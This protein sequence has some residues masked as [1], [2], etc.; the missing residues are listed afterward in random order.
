MQSHHWESKL[1]NWLRKGPKN[2]TAGRG[3]DTLK[4]AILDRETIRV[5]KLNNWIITRAD[6]GNFRREFDVERRVELTDD[7]DYRSWERSLRFKRWKR[8]T[9]IISLIIQIAKP[10]VVK[11][12]D[13]FKREQCI[14]N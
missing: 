5:K 9:R 14:I 6:R 4:W 3:A 2:E 1:R 12:T 8:W 13:I 7:E 10:R 11:R